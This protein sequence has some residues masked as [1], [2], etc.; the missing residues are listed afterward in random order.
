[1]NKS[2]FFK[3]LA[4]IVAL[5]LLIGALV[6][7]TAQADTNGP[8]I[9]AM[10][11]EYGSELFL[12]YAVPAESFSSTPKLEI[13]AN[14]D[15][16]AV[17]ETV[18][19]YEEVSVHGTSCYVFKTKGVAPGQINKS[20]FVRAVDGENAGPVVEYSVE[21]YL[22]TR[23][24]KN[25]VAAA[26]EG[27][28]LVQR[29]LY[30]QLL[31]YGATA[32]SVFYAEDTD[33]IGE[34]GV[35]ASGVASNINGV[36][37]FGN[38]VTLT[39][40][41]TEG[42]SYWKVEEYTTFGKYVGEKLLGAGYEYVIG[43]K[44]AVITPVYNAASTEGV[45]EWDAGTIHFN[46][47]PGTGKFT[48]ASSF[49][50]DKKNAAELDVSLGG[51]VIVGEN[52]WEIETLP[53]GNNVL[54]VSKMCNARNESGT[55]LKYQK[56]DGSI[57][58]CSNCGVSTTTY[59]TGSVADA[60]VA[61]YEAKILLDNVLYQNGIQIAIYAG[62]TRTHFIYM[63]F[64]GIADGTDIKW[65]DR[66]GGAYETTNPLYSKATGAVLGEWFT[67]RLEYRVVD[68]DGVATPELKAFINGELKTTSLYCDQKNGAYPAISS[69][70]KVTLAL[71]NDY[72]GDIYYDDFG[73]NLIKE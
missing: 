44:S 73:L 63:P 69:I 45:E 54:H 42:F 25:G 48:I 50:S 3:I 60:N 11:V 72:K 1:M 65:Q 56:S 59:V 34:N 53:D 2:K 57:T 61:V 33:K 6:G 67:L 27:K 66:N 20:E 18:T 9:A 10:N 46:A 47:M 14:A 21:Q 30:Y 13:V 71:N 39:P 22:Y 38:Y 36:Y 12:Y 70:S 51:G 16:S 43:N 24:Y 17:L 23:L 58:T 7:I 41:A 40:N 37:A 49:E 52:T 8:E 5:G 26:T 32:Q 55:I 4:P 28:A 31:K 68:V 19:D 35:Y 64:S 62:S 15:A 29:S